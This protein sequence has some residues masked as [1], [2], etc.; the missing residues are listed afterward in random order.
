MLTISRTAL[1]KYYPCRI[2][3]RI[4]LLPADLAYLNLG[5]DLAIKKM[6]SQAY[7]ISPITS[8]SKYE[9]LFD[10]VVISLSSPTDPGTGHLLLLT[11]RCFS[12][13]RFCV[14]SQQIFHDGTRVSP[15]SKSITLDKMVFSSL[16]G[17]LQKRIH[18]YSRKADLKQIF[19]KKDLSIFN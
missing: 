12:L 14:M 18:I 3:L 15:I 2:S 9:R 19:T 1:V 8:S 10:S 5:M 6:I 16:A 13:V 7:P 11:F 4:G 17:P